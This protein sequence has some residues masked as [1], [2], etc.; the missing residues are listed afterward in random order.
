M[1]Q[2]LIVALIVGGSA[3]YAGRKYLPAKWFGREKAGGCASGCDTC[4]TCGS[5]ESATPSDTR[6]PVI[7]LHQK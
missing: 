7:K 1:L 6:Y 4:G 5:S 3:W 2:D